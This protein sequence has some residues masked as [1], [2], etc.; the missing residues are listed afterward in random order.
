MRTLPRQ[1]VR[2]TPVVGLL[3][4]TPWRPIVTAGPQAPA[5][6]VRPAPA[7]QRFAATPGQKGATDYWLESQTARL[8]TRFDD[9]TVA[10]AERGA[11]GNFETTLTDAAGRDVGRFK[12]HRVSA[13]GGGESVLQYFSQAGPALQVYG[14][15]SVR[16]TLQWANAQAYLLL[17]DRV[18][19]DAATLEWQ[20]GV[21]RRKGMPRR[22]VERQVTELRTEWAHGLSATMTRR[23]AV[24]VKWGKDRL[25]NGEV[26]VSRLLKDDVQIGSVNWFVKEKLLVWDI[27]GVTRGSLAAEHLKDYGGWPFTPDAEWLNLQ[28]IAFY[29]FKTVMD[30]QGLV[31]KRRAPE[32][33]LARLMNFFVAPVLADDPGCDGLHWLDGTVLRYCCDNHDFCYEKSGCTSSSWWQVWSSWTC[34]VCNASAVRCFLDGGFEGPFHMSPW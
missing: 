16:P 30:Q 12:V 32:S 28:T 5:N 15:Q 13:A 18:G 29:H 14:D 4:L 34:D 2:L 24:N 27:P 25:L 3:C 17:K 19:S 9:A 22:D 1:L 20:N 33:W 11:D 23:T 21:M 6:A 10:V 31:A 8:T 7:G 26:L